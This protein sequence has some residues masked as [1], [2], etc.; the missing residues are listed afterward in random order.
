MTI[1]IISQTER[2]SPMVWNHM[3]SPQAI[4][5]NQLVDF[6]VVKMSLL[7]RNISFISLCNDYE[8]DDEQV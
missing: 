3:K 5:R 1:A 2:I 6:N 4:N 7:S 8:L